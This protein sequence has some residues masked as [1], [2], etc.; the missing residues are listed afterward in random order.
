MT[1]DSN[2]AW[3]Q[4]LQRDPLADFVYGVTSTKIFCRPSCPSRRPRR[5]KIQLFN[6]P[7]EAKA[8][9][10]RECLRCTPS[11][12]IVEAEQV[13]Q[14]CRYL[15]NQKG[16]QVSLTELGQ[17]AKLSPF[18]VQRQFRKVLGVS[19]SAYQRE[20]RVALFQKELKSPSSSR[21]AKVTEALFSAGYGSTSRV[22]E[23]RRLGMTPRAY[24]S[25]GQA[26]SIAYALAPC[27]LGWILAAQTSRGI[28][29]IHL[30]EREEELL[31]ALK[32][33]FPLANLEKDEA[34]Q[35]LIPNVLQSCTES[36]SAKAVPLD[37]RGTAFQRRVWDELRKIPKGRTISY[38]E[39]AE[40][41]GS[42]RAIRAV[43]SACAKNTL[44]LLVPCHRVVGKKGQLAGYRWGLERKE[45]LLA[46]EKESV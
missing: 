38:S 13:E 37:I 6:T 42:P 1:F 43:A 8:A 17:R 19:P 27:S 21:K 20:L 16:R 23:E 25:G 34:L 4:I 22:Y 45:K 35:T 40:Q 39:L 36:G 26:E 11:N 41:I 31:S 14:L 5:D 32:Q 24:L 12:R 46:M 44:A 3:Q 15:Q 10:F 28:C 9:G 2:L 7:T 33:Q 30:G 18:T 29:A